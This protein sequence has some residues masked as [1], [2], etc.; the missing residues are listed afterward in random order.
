MKDFSNRYIFLFAVVM[1]VIVAAVLSTAA[2]LLQPLQQ[3]NMII[4]KKLNILSS[5]GVEA[6]KDDVFERFE[7][8]I[9][10]SYAIN[11]KGE[12]IEGVDAFEV[13]LRV[14]QRKPLEE[15]NLPL[16]IARLDDEREAIIIPLEGRGLWGPIFGYIALEEDMNTVFGINLD[17][18]GETPGLGAEI[19]TSWY[20]AKFRGKKI[21]DGDRFVSIRVVKGGAPADDQHA[22]D[23]ISGGTITSN[24]LQDML[25]D[26][27]EKYLNYFNA[28]RD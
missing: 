20:E 21:F 16:F 14:E 24:G 9:E 27:L 6:G 28:R 17:H 11:H 18:Q 19:N 3:A 25:Y 5:V 15:Q 12:V 4:E 22:V 7:E 2:M 26:N 10:Q 13:D 23:A 8:A 1:V